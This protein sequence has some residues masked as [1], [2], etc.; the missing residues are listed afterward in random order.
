MPG[1]LEVNGIV[2]S[3]AP[4]KE[5]DKRV[6]L[7]TKELGRVTAFARGA[8]RVNSALSAPTRTFAFGKFRLVPGKDAYTLSQA[9]I[10]EYFEEIVLDM[11][12][13]AY[14]CYLL[15]LAACFSRENTEETETLL[16]VYYA[17]KAMVKGKI[18]LKLIQRITELKLLKISGLCPD[19]SVCAVGKEPLSE[20]FFRTSLMQPVCGEHADKDAR[21]PLGK[22][23][24][25]A[26]DLITRT[27]PSALFSF[28]L[29]DEA[30]SQMAD[31]VELLLTRNWDKEPESRKM[32]TVLT[33]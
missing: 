16:L 8:K 21:Y 12:K 10:T 26:L 25:Y 7:L 24:L 22:S 9:E 6:M 3:A 30:Y 20:G 4:V 1:Q 19:F 27:Q 29:S 5:A 28:V 18:P 32:L 13:T 11:E 14:G 2:L 31:V 33:S 17:L 23:A 15:D